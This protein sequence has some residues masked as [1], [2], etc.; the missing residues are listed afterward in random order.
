MIVPDHPVP[1]HSGTIPGNSAPKLEVAAQHPALAGEMRPCQCQSR[2][3]SPRGLIWLDPV[4]LAVVSDGP[5]QNVPRGL[6]RV[7]RERLAD[8]R[9]AAPLIVAKSENALPVGA[10]GGRPYAPRT[11]RYLHPAPLLSVNTRA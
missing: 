10:P 8:Q 11:L 5:G 1:D 3:L 6:D 4:A 2:F 9:P 7:R